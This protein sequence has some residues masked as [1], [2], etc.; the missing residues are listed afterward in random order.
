VAA[1]NDRHVAL[2]KGASVG[3]T[4]LLVDPHQSSAAR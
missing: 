3:E 2:A 4:V 1:Q